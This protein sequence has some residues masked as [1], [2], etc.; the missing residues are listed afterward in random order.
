MDTNLNKYFD[1][2]VLNDINFKYEA[3]K[4]TVVPYLENLTKDF[5]RKYNTRTVAHLES[6]IKKI[7]RA[8]EKLKKRKLEINE[9]NIYKHIHDMIGVRIVCPFLHD[10]HDVISLIKSSG[11]A[12]MNEKNFITDPK[13]SGYRGYH[14]IVLIPVKFSDHT[15][16]VEVE[17]QIKT[18][19]MHAWDTVQHNVYEKERSGRE[20]NSRKYR[21]LQEMSN[22]FMLHDVDLDPTFD[23]KNFVQIS[24]MKNYDELYLLNNSN[25]KEIEFQKGSTEKEKAKTL[26]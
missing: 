16:Y 18:S 9:E 8:I 13:T 4:N 7:D 15:E 1:D 22:E 19:L 10:V 21:L 5:E 14:L 11:L 23:L 17:I 12:I 2:K 6:R 25:E 3:T 26:K 20:V 24:K